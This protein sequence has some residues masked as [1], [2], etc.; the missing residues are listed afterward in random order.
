M[1][2]VEVFD[3]EGCGYGVRRVRVVKGEKNEGDGEVGKKWKG[4]SV[5][6]EMS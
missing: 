1:R 6:K 5:K 4:M 2:G 3:V